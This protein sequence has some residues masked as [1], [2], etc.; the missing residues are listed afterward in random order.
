[1]DELLRTIGRYVVIAYRFGHREGH[2]YLVDL[3][4]GID[5]A[6]EVADKEATERG[7]K[8]A[9]VVFAKRRDTGDIDEVYE[10]KSPYKDKTQIQ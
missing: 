9:V 10:A 4:A 1:M 7:G 8:Y 6:V 5:Q 2:S 3:C